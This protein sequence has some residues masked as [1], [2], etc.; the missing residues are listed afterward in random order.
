M[1]LSLLGWTLLAVVLLAVAVIVL[2]VKLRASGRSTP[3]RHVRLE[4]SLLGGLTPYLGVFDSARPRSRKEK[5][6]TPSKPKKKDRATSSARSRMMRNAPRLLL[7]WLGRFHFKHLNVRG[8]FGLGD[9]A[10]TGTVYGMLCPLIYAIPPG[11]RVDFALTPDFERP[12]LEG[13]FEAAVS[14]VPAGL[15]VSA[16]QFLWRSFGPEAAS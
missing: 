15:L 4:V 9:P 8:V 16:L 2:P 5:P 11:G 6:E 1:L 12:C 13:Q 10:E 7:D 14:V 3:H